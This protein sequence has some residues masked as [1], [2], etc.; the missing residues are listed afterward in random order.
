MAHNQNLIFKP[1]LI[2]GLFDCLWTG[3]PVS[4]QESYSSTGE[5]ELDCDYF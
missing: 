4:K 2:P 3:A 5:Q 1:S